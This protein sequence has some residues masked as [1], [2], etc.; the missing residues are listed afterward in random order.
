MRCQAMGMASPELISCQAGPFHGMRR[1]E[2]DVETEDCEESLAATSL[3]SNT[4]GLE[5]TADVEVWIMI[6]FMGC[7][8]I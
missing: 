7:L 8:K 4:T 5:K 6:Y 2:R 3:G 1:V